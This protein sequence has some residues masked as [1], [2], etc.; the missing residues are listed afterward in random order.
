MIVSNPTASHVLVL[1]ST[2][3]TCLLGGRRA[4]AVFQ[5]AP[6]PTN[7]LA[8]RETTST[9]LSSSSSPLLC[10]MRTLEFRARMLVVL[11]VWRWVWIGDDCKASRL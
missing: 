5:E 9:L 2:C 4:L 11:D 8:M 1:R 6:L 3:H 7:M 10:D